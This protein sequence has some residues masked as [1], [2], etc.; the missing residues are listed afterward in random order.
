MEECAHLCD[1]VVIMDQGKSIAR[2]SPDELV[3]ALDTKQVVEFQVRSKSGDGEALPSLC[4]AFGDSGLRRHNGWWC[5]HSD[6]IAITLPR[7]LDVVKKENCEL[8]A[9]RTREPT[10]EDVFLSLTG[11]SLRGG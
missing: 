7:L 11:R 2:G 3:R 5:L 6:E 10:L 8:V 4:S 1:R 9:L